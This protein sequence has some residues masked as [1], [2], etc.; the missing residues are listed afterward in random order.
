MSRYSGL[1]ERHRLDTLYVPSDKW[2]HT[3]TEEHGVD[4]PTQV[5]YKRQG[6]SSGQLGGGS[7]GA[8]H[9]E[10]LASDCEAAPVLR[11]VKIISKRDAEASKIHWQQEV[12]NLI[13]LSQNIFVARYRPEWQVKIGD[14][15]FSKRISDSVSTPFSTRGTIKYMAPEYRD[16]LNNSESSDFTT[17]VD[18]WSFGCLIYELFTRRCPFDEGDALMRYMR[19]GAFPTRPLDECGASNDSIQLIVKLLD[20]DPYQRWSSQDV[21]L[22]QWLNPTKLPVVEGLVH[23]PIPLS[24]VDDVRT[25]K[26]YDVAPTIHSFQGLSPPE[27]RESRIRGSEV[28]EQQKTRSTPDFAQKLPVAASSQILYHQQHHPQNL[29]IG[30]N[31]LEK[32]GLD[33]MNPD[34]FP[35]AANGFPRTTSYSNFSRHASYEKRAM[36]AA[37]STSALPGSTAPSNHAKKTGSSLRDI[38]NGALGGLG[39][40]SKAQEDMFQN[41]PPEMKPFIEALKKMQREKGMEQLLTHLERQVAELRKE[42]SRLAQEGKANSSNAIPTISTTVANK[43]L[44]ARKTSTPPPLPPRPKSSMTTKLENERATEDLIQRLHELAMQQIK[45]IGS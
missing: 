44:S 3:L 35:G 23:L 34:F 28:D 42:S 7:F 41:A 25:S 36:Q 21:L 43:D 11:A 8:V 39:G 45:S 14:F 20:R 30:N 31:W 32:Q 18:M 29:E 16:L 12:E 6:G 22:S 13:V 1:L 27:G 38:T 5:L 4:E 9:L 2:L 24:N 37:S 17:A 15:G 33:Q 26:P 10:V 40:F 19:N